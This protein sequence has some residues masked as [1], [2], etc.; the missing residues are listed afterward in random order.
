MK[1]LPRPYH[2]VPITL[3]DLLATALISYGLLYIPVSTFLMLRHGGVWR[4]LLS[5]ATSY[6]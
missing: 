1:Y 6:E 3:A 4:I 2:L 5:L